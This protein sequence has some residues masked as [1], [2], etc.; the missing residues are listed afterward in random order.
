MEER[1]EGGRE[2]SVQPAPSTELPWQKSKWE[3]LLGKQNVFEAI[4]HY[5]PI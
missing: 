1:E 4:V 5:G 3:E 2:G